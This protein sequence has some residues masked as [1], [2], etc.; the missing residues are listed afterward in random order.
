MAIAE[1]GS[2]P[3]ELST[4]ITVLD[5][6][7]MQMVR[8]TV[9]L[10]HSTGGYEPAGSVARS[11]GEYWAVRWQRADGSIHGARYKTER[12]ARAHFDRLS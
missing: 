5:H 2:Y 7:Y 1:Y 4:R 10:I 3:H 11:V 6:S 9:Y 12:E 8:A